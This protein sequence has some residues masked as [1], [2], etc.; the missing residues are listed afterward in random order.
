[1]GAQE[2]GDRRLAGLGEA[3][4][5]AQRRR[6]AGQ[7]V[8]VEKDPAQDLAPLVGVDRA[9]LAELLGQVVED[10]ARLAEALSRVLEDGYLAHDIHGPES[11]RAG[12][13]VEVVDEPRLPV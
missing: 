9:E 4:E 5:I 3:H 10:D 12:L 6:V 7:L 1:A 8:I 13:A 2:L 11:R